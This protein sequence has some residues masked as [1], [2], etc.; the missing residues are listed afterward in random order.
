MPKEA[1]SPSRYRKDASKTRRKRGAIDF[2]DISD[3]S[4]AQLDAMR[5]VGRRSD[6]REQLLPPPR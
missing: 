1:K 2:S 6:R 4:R 3:S 5:R